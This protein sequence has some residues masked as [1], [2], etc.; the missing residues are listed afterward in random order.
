MIY[1]LNT[2]SLLSVILNSGII[3]FI[4][5]FWIICTKPE[6]YFSEIFLEELFIHVTVIYDENVSRIILLYCRCRKDVKFWGENVI[7]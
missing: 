6:I 3:I 5:I 2:V 4:S 7:W 1:I